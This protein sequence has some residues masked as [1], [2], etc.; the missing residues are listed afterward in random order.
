MGNTYLSPEDYEMALANGVHREMAYRR[1]YKE[2]WTKEKTIN[3]PPY[4]TSER[5]E[6]LDLAKEHH[7]KYSTLYHRIR[8][9]WNPIK[10][11]TTKPQKRSYHKHDDNFSFRPECNSSTFN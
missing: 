10:A 2:G 9:G 6:L 8:R 5:Q 11:A 1:F 7:V 3:W 4:Q